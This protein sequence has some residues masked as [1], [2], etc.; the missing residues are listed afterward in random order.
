MDTKTTT[1]L[2]AMEKGNFVRKVFDNL[3]EYLIVALFSAF[4]IIILL[5]VFRRYVFNASSDWGEEVARYLFVYLVYLSASAAVKRRSHLRIE[6]LRRLM[7]PRLKFAVDLFSDFCF[8]LTAILIIY[9]SA[10]II[11]MQLENNTLAQSRTLIALKFNMAYAYFALPLGWGLMFLRLIQR[12]LV[13][14]KSFLNGEYGDVSVR[15]G[16]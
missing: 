5:E 2:P 9:F 11:K 3:E 14:I 15:V 13:T 8:M 4:T 16:E 6:I 12:F 7:G 10:G 1:H